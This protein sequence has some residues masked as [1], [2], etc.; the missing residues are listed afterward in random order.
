MGVFAEGCVRATVIE[1]AKLGYEVHV[2]VN[3]VASNSAWNKC[4]AL[5]SMKR[6]GAITLSDLA[7]R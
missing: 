4:F 5:W 2:I 7:A 6:A 3:A 1:G